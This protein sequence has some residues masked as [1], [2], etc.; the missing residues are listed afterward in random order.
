MAS[1]GMIVMLRRVVRVGLLFVFVVGI[2]LPEGALADAGGAGVPDRWRPVLLPGQGGAVF[3][4]Y[5]AP[6]DLAGLEGL[7]SVM[8]ATGLGNGFDPGPGLSVESAPVLNYLAE[9]G[10]PVVFYPPHYGEFQIEGGRAR[11]TDADEALLHAFDMAGTFTALQLGE[12]G[13]YFH[14]LSTNEPWWRASYGADF[15]TYKHLMKPAGLKGYDTMPASRKEA[16]EQVRSYYLSR[17][18]DMRGRNASVTGHSHY[19]IYAAAWG[20][21]LIGLEVGENIAFAQSKFA[22]ARG[23]SRQWQRPWSVQISPWMNGSCTSSGPLRLQEDKTARGQDAGHS[24]S[25]YRRMALH[26]WFAGAAM[27]TPENSSDAFF[28]PGEP[29]WQLSAQGRAA[30]ETFAF[31]RAHAPGVP[32]TP[33]AIVLDAYAGYNAFQRHPW[34]VLPNTPGDLEL[35]DLFQEQLFPGS[36]HIHGRPFPENPEAS[37]LRPTP[38]GESCDVLLS[39]AP[40]DVLRGYPVLLLAGDHNFDPAFVCA[41]FEAV[42]G[43]SQLL[44]L[45]RHAAALGADFAAL[46]GSGTVAVLEDRTNPATGRPAAIADARLQAVLRDHMPVDVEGDPVGYQINRLPA[47][48]VV[49]LINN[50]G[51]R[52]TPTEAAVIDAGAVAQVSITPRRVPS[53]VREWWTQTDLPVSE[54]ITVAIPPGETRYVELVD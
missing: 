5:G 11:L 12:W 46:Q 44:L 4:M 32:Y 36:D 29:R 45:P 7:V 6:S 33:L 14:D 41:L 17:N 25:F 37:F 27:V 39:N 43:G 53:A 49:E 51:V 54:M 42:R 16:Y 18:R 34:G 23:A 48:W 8:Q 15:D 31:M 35:Y 22:F 26:A 40:G 52:K 38:F 10:W 21:P 1:E 13:Y 47:G 30:T 24:M 2:L 19:E 3:T 28:E 20:A 9:L 50:E